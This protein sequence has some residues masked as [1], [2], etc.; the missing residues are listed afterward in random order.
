MRPSITTICALALLSP[1]CLDD[2]EAEFVELAAADDDEAEL[3]PRFFKGVNGDAC[4]ESPYNCKLRVSGGNRV[5]TNDPDDDNSWA[6]AAGVPIRDGNGTIV[7]TNSK[8]RTT[9]NYGQLRTFAGESYVFAV[10]TSNK[11]AGWMPLSSISGKTSFESK[12]GKVSALGS[13]LAKLGC[14]QI[15]DSHDPN[16]ELKKVVYDSKVTH[17]R[18][19]DYLPLV[20]ANGKR[21]ANLVFNVPGFSL[22]GVAVDHFPA[23]TKFQRLE[24]PTNS[25]P[26]SIDIP[27]YVK[28]GDG[29]YRKKDG[30]MK[31]IYGYVIA[32]TGTK[33][34]G[35][36]AY[37]ALQV[38][39]GCP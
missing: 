6:I 19:G 16:L 3:A 4:A 13:G 39:D 38:S 36:M 18:A 24:V 15:K 23:G 5:L 9:F 31:F 8:G 7:G 14:Y 29:R 34:N 12:L 17:E 11:S 2:D 22:G 25:G 21:S 27:L 26:P 32:A 30:T 10:S 35:W 37:D 20:R 33:R 28:D 1:A